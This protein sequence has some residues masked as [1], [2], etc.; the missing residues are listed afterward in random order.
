MIYGGAYGDDSKVKIKRFVDFDY[1]GCMDSR[2]F[3]SRYVFTMF[4]TSISCKATL[5]KVFALLLTEV[6]KEALWLK[7][8][9]KKLKLQG[10]T[11]T[12]KCDSQS[13]IHL[14]KNLAYH[15]R[16]KF[17]DLRVHFVRE[18]IEHGEV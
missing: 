8:F 13:A 16:T 3:I 4:G 6:V 7:G 18:I 11:I 14:S 5:Q 9:A 12:F 1:T 2:K 15:E 17:I 10:Q